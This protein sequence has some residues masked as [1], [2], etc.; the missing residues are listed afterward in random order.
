MAH[1]SKCLG[2]RYFD[3]YAGK[4]NAIQF[5]L[6][7][8]F[9]KSQ[10]AILDKETLFVI[11]TIFSVKHTNLPITRRQSNYLTCGITSEAVERADGFHNTVN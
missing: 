11:G 2:N 8:N 1:Q 3:A 5:H 9:W 7:R 10:K 4:I 6:K